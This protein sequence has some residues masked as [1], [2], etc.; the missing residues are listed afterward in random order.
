VFSIITK[1]QF[2]TMYYFIF[3]F[4]L[5]YGNKSRLQLII[6]INVI[7]NIIISQIINLYTEQLR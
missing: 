7:E 6:F 2:F 1:I 5:G 3:I 4:V